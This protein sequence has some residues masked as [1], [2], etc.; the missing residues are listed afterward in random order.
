[1]DGQQSNSNRPSLEKILISYEEFERL[2]NIESEYNKN[3]SEKQKDFE[4]TSKNKHPL[5][6]LG[7]GSSHHT[8]K[9]KLN[10]ILEKVE[11][12]SDSDDEDLIHRIANVVASK[13]Q[14]PSTSTDLFKTPEANQLLEISTA[15][16]KTAPPLPFQNSIKKSD[17]NDIFGN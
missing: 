2:K 3:Q 11:N 8:K 6:Q 10:R 5:A 12:D 1:M 7:E 14:Q 9:S 15:T 4:I 16:P 17:E 13:I